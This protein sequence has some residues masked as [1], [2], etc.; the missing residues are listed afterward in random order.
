MRILCMSSS[1]FRV[2]KLYKG[3]GSVKFVGFYHIA[4]SLIASRIECSRTF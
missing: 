4:L 2:L 1:N 3:E